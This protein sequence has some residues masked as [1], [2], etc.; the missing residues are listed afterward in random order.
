M[1]TIYYNNKKLEKILISNENFTI[2]IDFFFKDIFL[3]AIRIF[4]NIDIN[5]KNDIHNL[6]VSEKIN[7]SF[8]GKSLPFIQDNN[9]EIQIPLDILYNITDYRYDIMKDLINKGK[10]IKQYFENQEKYINDMKNNIYL[11]IIIYFLNE[12]KEKYFVDRFIKYLELSEED[13]KI[14]L[15]KLITK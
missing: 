11:G 4:P 12:I 15:D 13:K 8:I 1:R 3:Y 7:E 9:S 10:T 2:F 6:N 5:N 14:I